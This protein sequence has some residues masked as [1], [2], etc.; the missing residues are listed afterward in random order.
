MNTSK[1]T[2][3]PWEYHISDHGLDVYGQ[4]KHVCGEGWYP[5]EEKEANA[6][7]IAAAPE[8]LDACESIQ[9][10][11]VRTDTGKDVAIAYAMKM[12]TAAIRK[13]KG[14]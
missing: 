6:R 1:H 2:P 8:L 9:A 12:I 5:R 3:G 14:E 10:A 11:W 13:T 7:L 4:K